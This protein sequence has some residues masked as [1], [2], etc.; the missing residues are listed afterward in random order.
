[1]E[2]TLADKQ[3]HH[4]DAFNEYIK[5]KDYERWVGIDIDRDGKIWLATHKGILIYD[6][7]TEHGSA[8]SFQIL[9]C[10]RSWTRHNLHIYCDRDGIVWTSNWMDYGIYAIIPHLIHLLNGMLQ[11]QYKKDSLSNGLISTIVPWRRRVNCGLV[12]LME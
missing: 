3:F 7:K 9:I 12:Q 4:I 6:P 10:K 11:T 5:L 1:M 2:F 8:S